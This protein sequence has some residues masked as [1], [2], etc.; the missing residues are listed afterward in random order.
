MVEVSV[1]EFA[2]IVASYVAPV[3]K[4]VQLTP[5]LEPRKEITVLAPNCV[6]VFTYPK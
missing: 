4:L 6:A 2:S 1:A 5:S 3:F